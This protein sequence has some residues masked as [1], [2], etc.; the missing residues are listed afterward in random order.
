MDNKSKTD[1]F[2]IL[3]SLSDGQEMKPIGQSEV[4]VDNLDPVFVKSFTVDYYFE[5]E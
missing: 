1:A 3:Y 5:E 4:V 2:L